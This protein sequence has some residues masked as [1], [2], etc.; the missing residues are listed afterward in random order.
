[1]DEVPCVIADNLTDE[2]IKALR[3][4]DNKVGELAEWDEALLNIELDEI[5]DLDMT[6]FGFDFDIDDEEPQENEPKDLSDKVSDT[7]EVIVECADEFQ[8]EEVFSRLSGEGLK[9]RVLTL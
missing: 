7:Y 2:Q 9:C 3:L 4:A 5:L 6:D 8:Q 1:M